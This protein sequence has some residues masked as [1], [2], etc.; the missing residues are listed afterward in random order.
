M[1]KDNSLKSYNGLFEHMLDHDEMVLA[2]K[3]ASK[4]H[5]NKRQIKR[6]NKHLDRNLRR[7]KARILNKTWRPPKHEEVWISEGPNRKPRNIVKPDWDSEQI[8]HHMLMKEFIP[9]ITPK[10]SKYVAGSIK[11]RGIHYILRAVKRW[12][13]EYGDTPFYVAEL[14]I[15][16]FYDSIDLQ[17]LKEKLSRL[18]RDKDYLWL[19]YQTIDQRKRGLPKGYYI[20]PWLS[21]FYMLEADD[22]ILQ[23]LKPDHYAR[24]VDNIYLFSTSL[25]DLSNMVYDLNNYLNDMMGLEIKSNWQIYPF[26]NRGINCLGFYI[27]KNKIRIRKSV[28]KRI[29]SKANHIAAKGRYTIHDCSSMVS[30][31][32][33]FKYADAHQYYLDYIKPK[34]SIRYCKRRISK[35]QKELNNERMDQK[36]K[37]RKAS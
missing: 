21:H 4:N 31:M 2:V 37:Y 3:N 30:R 25:E 27:C 6:Y 18:I 26:G 23:E 17:L 9:I 15:K 32:S 5:K 22:Y 16:K 24:Y 34:V 1:R 20:S 33:W 12:V 29:R 8:V 36:R 10:I 14:D 7:L 28:L 35:R 19:L 11:G 13:N